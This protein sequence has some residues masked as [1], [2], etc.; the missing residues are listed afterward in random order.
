M[1]NPISDFTD[2]LEDAG[3]D[4]VK[5]F[6]RDV[7]K[8]I[9]EAAKSQL[10]GKDSSVS[11]NSYENNKKDKDKKASTNNK[12][13]DQ[14]KVDPMTGKPV[15]K[16][17]QLQHLSQASA[18]LRLTKLKKVRE[19]LEKQR[20]K[21]TDKKAGLAPIESSKKQGAGPAVPDSSEREKPDEAVA[22]T[23]KGSKDTGEF[24]GLIGG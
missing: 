18:Q 5:T 4:V 13:D 12:S 7:V 6:V 20:L 23:L 24:K 2:E 11:H 22:N 15:P 16:K 10:L 17:P 9:P 1:N 3:K 21:V 14:S 19:E 8:G